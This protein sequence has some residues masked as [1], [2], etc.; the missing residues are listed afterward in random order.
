MGHGLL[1]LDLLRS[2]AA[3]EAAVLITF[4]S[5][6]LQILLATSSCCMEAGFLVSPLKMRNLRTSPPQLPFPWSS[7]RVCLWCIS[8]QDS[9]VLL[10]DACHMVWG[11]WTSLVLRWTP[12]LR[13]MGSRPGLQ[14]E[15]FTNAPVCLAAVVLGP[16]DSC[17]H[18][19]NPGLK[20]FFMFLSC[21]YETVFFFAFISPM[22]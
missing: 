21:R 8:Q 11:G 1:T 18:F 16:L 19:P 3:C 2:W 15:D 4:K 12:S 9:Q 10:V 14:A 13:Q 22:V 6:R 20:A 17:S 5:Y 7:G